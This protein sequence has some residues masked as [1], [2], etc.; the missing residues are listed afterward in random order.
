MNRGKLALLL[1]M[2]CGDGCLTTRTRKEGYKTYAIEFFNTDLDLVKKFQQLFS[3][4]F[5]VDGKIN[6][7]IKNNRKI[8]YVFRKYSKEIF[9][10]VSDMG[11][12]KGKKKFILKIPK[13]ILR[14]NR[15]EKLLFLKGLTITDGSIK[16][17]GQIV[18]HMS[19]KLFL[20]DVSDLIHE[21]FGLR[22]NLR[23]YIQKEKYFSY[24][25][26]LN[27]EPSQEVLKFQ[28]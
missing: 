24:Q 10:K 6:Q 8:L 13:V 25:L 4:I 5:E 1:G 12:P 2:L 19:S 11:F 3:E 16:K 18:F 27:K 17:G 14:G 23:E 20:E 22:K 26:L 15:K 7:E 21:L 28:L 9:E